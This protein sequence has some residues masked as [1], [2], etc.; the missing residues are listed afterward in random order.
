MP[1]KHRAPPLDSPA[2]R[3]A[4]V[5]SW[6][7]QLQRIDLAA[8]AASPFDL[9][10]IDHARDGRDATALRPADL[11]RLRRKP[12][13]TRRLVYAYLSV[14]EAEDYRWYW[15]DEW[16]AAPPAWLL[17]ENAD[18][19]GNYRVAF[20]HSA[21][22]GILLGAHGYVDRIAA[23]GFDGLYLDRCD[24]HDDIARHSRATA[25]ARDDLEDKAAA[26]VRRL[27]AAVRTTHPR[28]GII[29]QNAEHLLV[30]PDVRR[31]I[32]AVAKEEM[33]FGQTM[34]G[35]RNGKAIIAENRRALDLMKHDGK[36]V[37]AVEYLDDPAKRREARAELA[38]LGYIAYL[39]RQDRELATLEI[40]DHPTRA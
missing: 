17:G 35:R 12:D 26:F 21:W 40:D 18:W 39:A 9:L 4:E 19:P 11:A 13:G 10:V 25:A 33:L 8:A 31:A 15:R 14:G 7:Y 34:P 30:R 28:L 23:A 1:R 29:M 38:A 20:W 27:S 16:R 24:V 37:F 5:A 2:G 3:L 22:Q 6:G 36:A 32:D